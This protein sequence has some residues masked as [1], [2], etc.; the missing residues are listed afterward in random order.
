M[1]KVLYIAWKDLLHLLHDP[2]A[3]LLTLGT[4][5]ALTL[6]IAFAFGGSGNSSLQDIRITLVNQDRGEFGQ[7]LV[8]VFNSA[9]LA[10]LLEPS[11]VDSFEIARE[12]VENGEM[13]VAVLIPA[14]FSQA[15]LPFDGSSNLSADRPAAN[16]E[17]YADPAAP[18]S[19]GVVRSIVEEYLNR[20]YAGVA[21]AQVSITQ[22]IQTGRLA[23]EQAQAVGEQIGTRA[24]ESTVKTSLIV[25]KS[26]IADVESENSGFNWLEYSA[27]SMAILFLM[28]T[29]TTGGR[30]ILAEREAGTL[31]RLLTTPT[32]SAQVLGGKVLGIF[33]TG[34]F[35]M[36][37]LFVASLLLL[38]VSWGPLELVLPLIIFVV[39]AATSWSILIAAL[40]KTPGQAN[41]LGTAITLVFAILSG[42]FFPR[43]VMPD[44]L[45]QLG[46]ITP[47]AWGLD[48]F[49]VIRAG[50]AW[51]GLTPILVALLGMS[52][53]LFGI[54]VLVFRRSIR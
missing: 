49:E 32:T 9:E 17:I 31:P 3:L 54:A 12:A 38:R 13:V 34:F 33:T 16:V 6:V 50:E 10:D 40:S 35:Q 53:V 5:F 36:S 1:K 11:E 23:P 39:L 37:V 25:L 14:E 28:F 30:K 27:P 43:Q 19:T 7:A 42:N 22:M 18:I 41:S 20:L 46:K 15:I 4:P 21:G 48:G 2:A 51:A 24:A 26:T 44:W 45:F 47:N 29:V 52:V 8:D